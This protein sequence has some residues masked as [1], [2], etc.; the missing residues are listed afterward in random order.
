[1]KSFFYTLLL[2][3]LIAYSQPRV[4]N[5]QIIYRKDG[6]TKLGTPIDYDSYSITKDY[7]LIREEYTRNDYN[8]AGVLIRETTFKNKKLKDY[9]PDAKIIEYYDNGDKK[10]EKATFEIRKGVMGEKI[11]QFWD[12]DKNQRVTDGNGDY[13]EEN[14]TK[15]ISGK[16]RYN[17]KDGEWID[18]NKLLKI[19][20]IEKYEN[21]QFVSGVSTTEDG[22][23][24]Q[25]TELEERPKPKYGMSDFYSFI[26]KNFKLSTDAISN[27]VN[28][29]I[30]ATFMVEKN[31]Q[32]NEIKILRDIGYGTGD[33]AIRVLDMYGKWVPGKQKGVPTRVMYSIPISVNQ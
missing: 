5:D 22:K 12:T 31:G 13:H 21:G 14:D 3:P 28:G 23:K 16:V 33:E 1:M 10:V 24:Y 15:L 17:L 27:K 20:S 19:S 32:I 18:N 29:K 9:T 2:L 4:G 26:G 8:K 30:F 25:Y 6:T 7:Y 11:Y